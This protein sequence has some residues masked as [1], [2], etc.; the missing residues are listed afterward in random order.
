MNSFH[1]FYKNIKVLTY[2]ILVHNDKELYY[3]KLKGFT[4]KYILSKFYI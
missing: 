2:F 1:Y 4:E 3:K